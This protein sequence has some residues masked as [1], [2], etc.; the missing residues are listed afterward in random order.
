[1]NL[2]SKRTVQGIVTGAGRVTVATTTAGTV[3]RGDASK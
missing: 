3:P 2:Q 1:M